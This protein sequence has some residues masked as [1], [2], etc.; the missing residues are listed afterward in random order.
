[1]MVV[2]VEIWPGGSEDYALEIGRLEIA[3]LSNLADVSDYAV[4]L[5]QTAAEQLEVRPID[6]RTIIKA[7]TRRDGPWALIKRALD[8]ILA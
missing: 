3:N 7:H 6:A 4:R 5:R 1:M 8:Q 2:K